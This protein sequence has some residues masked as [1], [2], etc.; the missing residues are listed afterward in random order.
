VKIA[1]YVNMADVISS[2]HPAPSSTAGGEAPAYELI[3]L[4]FFA[5]RDFVR[6]ADAVLIR[7]G[8]GRAHHRVLHFVS[9]NPGL[10]V[11]ELLT[12]LKITKQSLGR[13]LREL[14]EQG[15]IEAQEGEQDRRQ[16]LLRVTAHGERLARE[17]AELQTRRIET[18]LAAAGPGAR[19]TAMHFLGAMIDAGERDAVQHLVTK[20]NH[21]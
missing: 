21:P 18:A 10:K 11:A 8:F 7:Y 20:A 12:I 9:R 4:L 1:Q 13:V 6:E 3:E 19:E 14:V 5:Y 15:F 16:R 17:L 2:T